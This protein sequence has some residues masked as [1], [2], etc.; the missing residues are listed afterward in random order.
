MVFVM[1]VTALSAVLAFTRGDRRRNLLDRILGG[2]TLVTEAISE[3]GSG[4]QWW[5][6]HSNAVAADRG[7]RLQANKSFCTSAGYADLY[8][9]STRAPEQASDRRH[10]L[11]LVDAATDGISA[12]SWNGL[13]LRGNMSSTI[14]FDCYVPRDAL[15]VADDGI[16][17]NDALREYNEI[18]QPL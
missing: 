8:V 17:D 12:G 4:S 14:A 18:N 11:F 9:V 15:L 1:H 16:G 7:Y 2:E 10:A 13:G 6:V 5:S 3:P